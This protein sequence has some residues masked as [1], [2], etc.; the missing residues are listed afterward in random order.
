MLIEAVA[1]KAAH[2]Q[3]VRHQVAMS[4]RERLMAGYEREKRSF[5]ACAARGNAEES[6]E[7]CIT[8]HTAQESNVR[9]Q[10]RSW[11]NVPHFGQR[12]INAQGVG[13]CCNA[14]GGVF[15]FAIPV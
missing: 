10:I 1:L 7:G 13:D 14:H 6:T 12:A 5:E 15:A 2:T 3:R 8:H 9:A 11:Q 4:S